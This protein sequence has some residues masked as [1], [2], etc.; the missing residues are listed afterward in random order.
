MDR[1]ILIDKGGYQMA[2]SFLL[3]KSL[4]THAKPIIEKAILCMGYILY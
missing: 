1:K 2:T 3:P 4:Y